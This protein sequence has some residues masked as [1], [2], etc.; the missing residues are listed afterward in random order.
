MYYTF[1]NTYIVT[2]KYL[3]KRVVVRKRFEFSA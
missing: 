1:D 3:K 2:L